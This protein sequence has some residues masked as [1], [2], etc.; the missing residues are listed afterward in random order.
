MSEEQQYALDALREAVL[1]I[2]GIEEDLSRV[3]RRIAEHIERLVDD[4]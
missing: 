4:A 2:A 1:N 3:K